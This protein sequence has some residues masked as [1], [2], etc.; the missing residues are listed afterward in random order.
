MTLKRLERTIALTDMVAYAGATWDWHRLHYDSKFLSE[1]NLPGPVVDG[2]MLGALMAEHVLD[3]LGPRAFIQTLDIKYRSMMFAGETVRVDSTRIETRSGFS[4][5]L[6]A[7]V[8]DR[9][10]AEGSITGRIDD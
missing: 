9:V 5:T 8:D 7:R 3:G 2:Q 4:Y 10:V 6:I 1:R